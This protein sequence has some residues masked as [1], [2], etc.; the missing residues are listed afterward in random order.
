MKLKQWQN[1]FHMLLNTNSI[2]QHVIQIKNKVMKH[3]S[4]NV[5]I[6]ISAKKVIAGI[7]AHVFLRIAII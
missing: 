7:L 5:K 2:V 4:V 1:I 3:A 6:I